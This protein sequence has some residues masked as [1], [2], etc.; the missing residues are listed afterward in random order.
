MLRFVQ[1]LIVRYSDHPYLAG[2]LLIGAV[3]A[4]AGVVV[5]VVVGNGLI[6]G[7]LVVY[8]LIAFFLGALGYALAI[9]GT[10]LRTYLR[11]TDADAAV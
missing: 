10:L 2:I 11:N 4:A 6:G 1:S 9:S 7:F 8:A 5:D 3:L